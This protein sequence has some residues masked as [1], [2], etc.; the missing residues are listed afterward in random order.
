MWARY[1]AFEY[2]RAALDQDEEAVLRSVE[3]LLAKRQAS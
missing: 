2:V 3:D 1:A